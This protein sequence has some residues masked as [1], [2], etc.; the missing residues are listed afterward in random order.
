MSHLPQSIQKLIEQ[1]AKLPGIGE[2]TASRMTFYLLTKPDDDIAA[3]A[4]AL[5]NLK[6]S[7]VTCGRCFNIATLNPCGI[8]ADPK[9]DQSIV[10]VVEEPLD[11]IALGRTGY[12]GVYHVLGGV[13]SPI[14]GVGPEDLRAAELFDKVKK[15]PKIAEVVLATDPSLEGEA[16]A[17]FVSKKIGELRV[18]GAVSKKLKVTRLGRGLPVG[19]DLEYADELT[20]TRALEGRSEF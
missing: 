13:I 5:A 1:F 2:K 17:L 7:L 12:N 6:K 16:T 4:G 20:L 15:D 19:G 11:V 14:D 3:F 18:D 9:R 10:M 8:C